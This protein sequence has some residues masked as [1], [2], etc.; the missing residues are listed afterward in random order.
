MR[1]QWIVYTLGISIAALLSACQPQSSTYSAITS[2]PIT[3]DCRFI[4]KHLVTQQANAGCLLVQAHKLLMVR[5]RLTGKYSLPGGTAER[6]EQAS[7][8]AH[9]ETW[10]ETGLDIM[11]G[12]QLHHFD[13][14]FRLFA[15]YIDKPA[16]T[17]YDQ[18]SAIDSGEINAVQWLDPVELSTDLWR[19]PQ[20]K[21]LLIMLSRQ[22][23]AQP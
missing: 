2:Q 21:Q 7:C 10:E 17:A 5:S 12:Q 20:Q 14:G 16:S 1:T 6:G 19:F 22:H 23:S 9:R 13:N 15:C 18:L 3:P 11:V 4:D 8:T